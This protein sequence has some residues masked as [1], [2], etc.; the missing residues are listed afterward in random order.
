LIGFDHFAESVDQGRHCRRRQSFKGAD[1][2]RDEPLDSFLQLIFIHRIGKSA[3][4]SRKEFRFGFMNIVIIL[5]AALK[6]S[7]IT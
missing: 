3:Q 5:R 6:F 1:N 4:E 2:L 7:A